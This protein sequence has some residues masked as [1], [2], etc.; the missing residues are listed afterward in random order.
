MPTRSSNG[1]MP[2]PVSNQEKNGGNKGNFD[3]YCF[4]KFSAA[5][6]KVPLLH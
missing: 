4:E 1:S 3:G 6:F 5:Y 2:N